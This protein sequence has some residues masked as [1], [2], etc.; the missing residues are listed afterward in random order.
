MFSL[1][2]LAGVGS[3]PHPSVTL[4]WSLLLGCVGLLAHICLRPHRP[5]VREL[6]TGSASGRTLLSPALGEFLS[7][8]LGIEIW[9]GHS[10]AQKTS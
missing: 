10:K 9:I 5:G 4:W 8:Y 6:C 7:R 2:V 1:C 3:N